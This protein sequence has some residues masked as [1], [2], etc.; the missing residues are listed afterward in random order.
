MKIPILSCIFITILCAGF[1]SAQEQDIEYRRSSLSMILLESESF[2]NQEDVLS[3]WSSYPFPEKYNQHDIETKSIDINSI[4]INDEELMEAGFLKDTLNAFQIMKAS[5]VGKPLRYLNEENTKAFALPTEKLE[6]QLKIDKIIIEKK[7]ANQLVAEWFN[8]S[9]DGKFDMSVIQERGFYDATELEAG[10]AQGQTRGM[11]S[12]GDAGEELIKNTF[13]SVT[14]LN[15]YENEP[16]A[17]GIRDAAKAL[18]DE[19]MKDSPEMVREAATKAADK[20]YDLAKDGYS[21]RSKTWLYQLNWSDSTAAIFYQDYW[22][23]PDAF[24]NSELFKLSFV[25]VQYNLSMV[26]FAKNKT[27]DQVIDKALVR[28]IDKA[29]VE[30]QKDNDVFKPKMPIL[31]VDPIVVL[32]GEKEDVNAKS[33]FEVLEMVWDK[34][35]GKTVWKS[36]GT[37]KL[38]KKYPIWDNRYNA[39]ET[40][41]EQVDSDGNVVY[42]TRFKGSKSI[43]PGMLVKQK[44]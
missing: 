41:E 29:F 42:G 10:I 9:E 40:T 33:E 24:Q 28:N 3:S 35:E 14:K 2:P 27:L 32:I 44:K 30:L 12:L 15:F 6:F 37:C 25:G 1:L 5:L 38:D 26:A 7:L 18:I 17:R 43:Q 23:N 4:E 11:S 21:L 20:A 31:S 8:L 39:G 34:K 16:F 13:V 36:I 19:T 22:N